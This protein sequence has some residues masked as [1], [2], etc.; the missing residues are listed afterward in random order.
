MKQNAIF[1]YSGEFGYELL[2]FQGILRKHRPNFDKMFVCSFPGR[3]ILYRDFAD[4]VLE[5]PTHIVQK[6]D[7]RRNKGQGFPAYKE[8]LDFIGQFLDDSFEIISSHLDNYFYPLDKRLDLSGSNGLYIKFKPHNFVQDTVERIIQD[9]KYL[10]LVPRVLPWHLHRNWPLNNWYQ[11]M[12]DLLIVYP[13]LYF[14]MFSFQNSPA[15]DNNC[16]TSQEYGF[17]KN[18]VIMVNNPSV[19]LQV[20]FINK[21]LG[22][23][24]NHSGAAFL[25]LFCD[26]P[27]VTFATTE[28]YNHIY[29]R[30]NLIH[31]VLLTKKWCALDGGVLKNLSVAAVVCSLVRTQVLHQFRNN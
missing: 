27:L 28:D 5:Y 31:D 20:E 19:E 6:I 22:S 8:V 4:L 14:V 21:S 1:I 2:S 9:K 15:L 11:L 29:A 12:K 26:A 17:L 16:Y 25:P 7:P 10:V 23:I 13:E 3:N 30:P 18:K 24:Y